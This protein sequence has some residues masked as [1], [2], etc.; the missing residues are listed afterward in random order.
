MNLAKNPGMKK[1]PN[2]WK[3]VETE[4]NRKVTRGC[5]VRG[6]E[7]VPKGQSSIWD[8]EIHGNTW[9]WWLHIIVNVTK[10]TFLATPNDV[11]GKFDVHFTAIKNICKSQQEML[12]ATVCRLWKTSQ[13]CVS[14]AFQTQITGRFVCLRIPLLP[15][16]SYASPSKSQKSTRHSKAHFEK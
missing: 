2:N 14:S 7:L 6:W 16:D 11:N 8:D 13:S 3:L 12:W 5:R 15:S 10:D 9:W 4:T 1:I